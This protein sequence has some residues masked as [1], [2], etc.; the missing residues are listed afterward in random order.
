MRFHHAL[1]TSFDVSLFSNNG[2]TES[3]EAVN[4]RWT[5]TLNSIKSKL[6]KKM[7]AQSSAGCELMINK[8]SIGPIH[9]RRSGFFSALQT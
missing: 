9:K 6:H 3:T 5:A 1:T 7:I 2:K 8:N 4:H